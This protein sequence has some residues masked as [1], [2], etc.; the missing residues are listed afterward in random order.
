ML[1]LDNQPLSNRYQALAQT[2][3]GYILAGGDFGLQQFPAYDADAAWETVDL[4][5]NSVNAFY[6]M[7]DGMWVGHSAGASYYDYASGKWTHLK[8]AEEAGEGIYEGGVTAITVDG[9]GQVW[10]GTYRG[11][12]VWDGEN[13]TYH[14]LLSEEEIAEEYSARQVKALYFDGSNVWVGGY[15]AFFRFDAD[16]EIT[17][18]D[19]EL[20]GLL[21]TF[22]A[23]ST[24]AFA[25]DP[26]GNVLLAVDRR[27]LSYDGASFEELY[28]AE[29][30]VEHI[31][32]NDSGELLLTLNSDGIVISDEGEWITLQASDGLASNHYGGQ[33]VL[34]DYLGTIWFASEDAG[35]VR[36]VP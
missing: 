21:A 19:D 10:F 28:E 25:Q 35:L 33:T 15:G 23:P 8:R 31:I 27:L 1:A 14:D 24:N 32:V 11:L 2:Q 6:P 13:F 9:A 29:S 20:E 3:D 16:G 4:E 30:Y 34:V 18:W 7:A 22:F 5:G 12:T 17:R 36:L 26:E